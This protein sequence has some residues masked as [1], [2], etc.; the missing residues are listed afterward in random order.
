MHRLIGLPSWRRE[1]AQGIVAMALV[2]P[3]FIFVLMGIVD[4]AM[5]MRAYVTVSNSSRE[6]ARYAVVCPSIVND[7]AIKARVFDFS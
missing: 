2:L 6:G 3:L 4:F 7:D 5:G 1:G